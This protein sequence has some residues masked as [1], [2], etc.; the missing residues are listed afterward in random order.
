MRLL[1][2]AASAKV[3]IGILAA[4]AI[5]FVPS[6]PAP[7]LPTWYYAFLLVVLLL[8]G[9]WLFVGGRRDVRAQALATLF[10]LFATLFSDRLL[11]RASAGQPELLARAMQLVAAIELVAFCPFALWR[12]VAAF[13]RPQPITSQRWVAP[14]MQ[15][16]TLLT[17]IVLLAGNVITMLPG[18]DRMGI[19]AALAWTSQYDQRVFWPVLTMLTIACLVLLIVKWKSAAPPGR[20]RLS[21]VVFGI[22]LGNAPML[23]HIMVGLVSPAYAAF[24]REPET[25]RA[26]GII[27][28]LFTL[29]I[30]LTTTYA[31]VEEQALNVS[32]VVRRAVQYAL[33]KYTVV[34]VIA[35]LVI[36]VALI[37][38]GNR[39]RT[40]ADLIAGSP[41][42]LAVS[43]MLIVLLMSRRA[44]LSAID[45]RFFRDQYNAQQ[46]LVTLTERSQSLHSAREV[47]SLLVMEVQRALHLERA[48]FLLVDD[49]GDTL[50]DPQGRVRSLGLRGPLGV[51]VSGSRAP[52]DVDLSSSGS[53][54]SRLPEAEREWLADAGA[55]LIVPVFGVRDVPIGLLVLG[56]KRS[57]LPFTDEDKRLMAAVASQAALALEQQ[58]NRESPN[59]DTP[60]SLPRS[61]GAQCVSCGRMQPRPAE[62]CTMC[63]GPIRDALL[64]IVVAGKFEVEQQIGAGGMGVVYRGK[65]LTLNRPVALK[66]LPRIGAAAATR[67]RREARAMA[68]LQH[69]NLALIHVMESWRGAPVLVLEYLAGGTLADRIRHR[70]LPI[71]EVL[72]IFTAMTEVLGHVHNAGYL[73]RDIKPSNLGF[74][75]H[76]VPKLLDF[77]LV[78]MISDVADGSTATFST[79]PIS[80]STVDG[81]R[82]GSGHSGT[83]TNLQLIGTP[84]YMSPEAVNLEPPDPR[85]DLWSLAITMYEAVTG[86]NPFRAPSVTETTKLV[87]A[88]DLPDA[89]G[90]RPDCPD[91]LSRFLSRA[92]ARDRSERPQSAAQFRAGLQASGALQA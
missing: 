80:G 22:A 60:A 49:S 30:P 9:T 32:F 7:A 87:T 34:A 26:L 2:A 83:V 64:P 14:A 68:A 48:A 56:D 16:A 1:F 11:I 81:V 55:R 45:R 21:W 89:R 78:Q 38:Y 77:G 74:T 82:G 92:L 28:T 61:N 6:P 91:G 73:H 5:I 42:A 54:L 62:R 51:L 20:R 8:S 10:V 69:T 59:L 66:V 44:L 15:Y 71:D 52:L 39:T 79:A 12:F 25:S 18:A 90:A 86:T 70:P 84:A 40:L 57:E 72:T 53:A 75:A 37:A 36:A 63:N 27:F 23:A 19:A 4:G 50:G 47:M 43:L 29:L 31:V 13:P 76:G 33:A 88:G 67:L 65:D 17:G 35:I 58:L 85:V 24:A 3:G 46:I 41:V